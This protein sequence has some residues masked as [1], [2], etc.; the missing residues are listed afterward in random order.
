MT[1]QSVTLLSYFSGCFHVPR[2]LHMCIKILKEMLK[3]NTVT[4]GLS[5]GGLTNGTDDT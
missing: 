4:N 5:N 3:G 1:L 2:C